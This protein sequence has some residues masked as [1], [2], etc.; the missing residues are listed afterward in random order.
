MSL[1]NK[2]RKPTQGQMPAAVVDEL[3]VQPSQ[4]PEN[5]ADDHWEHIIDNLSDEDIPL[6]T[7]PQIPEQN[8]PKPS[9]SSASERKIQIDNDLQNI[10][11]PKA[12]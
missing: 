11:A 2:L 6:P 9:A 1:E 10:E 8:T 7:A 3:A 4:E 12:K 5:V